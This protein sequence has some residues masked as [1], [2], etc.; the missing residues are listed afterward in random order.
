MNSAF[1]IFLSA[2][3]VNNIVLI[4]FLGL[5]P[6]LGV[7]KRLD[8]AAGMS[9]AVL[10]VMLLASWVTWTVYKFILVPFDI[11]YLR[12]A[13]FILVIASLVQFVE[14]FMRKQ[15]P[16]LY[17][18]LGIY[19]PLI[20]TNCAILGTTFLVIDNKYTFLST[21]VFAVGT[22]LGFAL[23]LILISSIRERLDLADIPDA[24]K[25][26]PIAFITASLMSLAFLGFVGLLGLSI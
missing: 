23:A 12:T 19:L 1:L 3:L 9:M 24:L 2:F 11:V 18:T 22:A 16:A 21:T 5:C 17:S 15:A 14:M 10:F 4:R 25:G 26:A 6:W 20:T 8:S 7:S 13:V